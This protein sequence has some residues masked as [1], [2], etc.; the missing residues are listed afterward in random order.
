MKTALQNKDYLYLYPLMTPSEIAEE[1]GER[2]KCARSIQI[3]YKKLGLKPANTKMTEI[4]KRSYLL[5]DT[6]QDR[7]VEEFW[8]AVA[9]ER[10]YRKQ[11]VKARLREAEGLYS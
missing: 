6:S 8:E 7:W 10:D 1:F 2:A 5:A 3:I 9:L 4:Y 11:V